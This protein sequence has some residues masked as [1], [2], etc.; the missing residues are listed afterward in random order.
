M[1][2]AKTHL[3]AGF[4]SFLL[5]LALPYILL[6]R[7]YQLT[8]PQYVFFALCSLLGSIFPDIDTKSKGQYFFYLLMLF[9]LVPL[10][11]YQHWIPLSILSILLIFPLLARHRGMTH[12]LWFVLFVPFCIPLTIAYTNPNLVTQA[13]FSYLFFI[14]GALS[15]LILDFGPHNFIR[16]GLFGWP[17][18]RK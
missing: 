18:R 1:P 3:L 9:V 17:R 5:L 16:R 13:F 6:S 8:I 2:K 11:I 15:H 12:N 14:A 7:S 10:I 4:F